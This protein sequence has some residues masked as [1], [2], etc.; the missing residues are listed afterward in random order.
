MYIIFNI[1]FLFSWMIKFFFVFFL[2]KAALH[3]KAIYIRG[4]ADIILIYAHE[5]DTTDSGPKWSL[6]V[7]TCSGRVP[8]TVKNIIRACRRRHS[9]IFPEVYTLYIIYYNIYVYLRMLPLT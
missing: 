1:F 8:V 4:K 9:F 6:T 5:P 7:G 3:A 2:N